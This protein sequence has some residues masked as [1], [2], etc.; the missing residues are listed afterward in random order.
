MVGLGRGGKRKG[1]AW[2]YYIFF[3]LREESEQE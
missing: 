3:C 1:V 2:D